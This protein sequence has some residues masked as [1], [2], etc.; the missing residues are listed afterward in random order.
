MFPVLFCLEVSVGHEEANRD[1]NRSEGMGL[2]E[3]TLINR[4][5]QSHFE[6]LCLIE[7]LMSTMFSI[8]EP[9]LLF[10]TKLNFHFFSRLSVEDR[11]IF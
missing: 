10:S 2:S 8:G 7:V 5:T 9:G 11:T 6:T 1:T 4:S 3:V